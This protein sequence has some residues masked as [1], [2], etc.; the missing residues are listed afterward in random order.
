[1]AADHLMNLKVRLQ[2]K[3]DI[4]PKTLD[5]WVGSFPVFKSLII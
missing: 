4:K 3:H 1:M 5:V 2:Y